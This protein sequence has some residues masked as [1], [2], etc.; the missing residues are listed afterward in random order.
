MKE[1]ALSQKVIRN[2]ALNVIGRSWQFLITIFLAPYVVS[3]LGNERYGIWVL[4]SVLTGYFGLLDLGVGFSFIK[5]ISEFYAKKD[6][7]KINQLINSGFNFYFFLSFIIIILAFFVIKPIIS[8]LKIPAPL[9][10]EAYWVFLLG[11]FLFALVNIMCPFMAIQSGLQ[12]MDIT[13]KVGIVM[14]IPTIVGT[15]F[16]LERGFGL[17][18]LI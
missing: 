11:L 2:T 4:V 5:Y 6:F 16:V 3:H 12:R 9:Q 8:L 10:N 17:L 15:I 18:G 1:E 14:S 7:K 13:N